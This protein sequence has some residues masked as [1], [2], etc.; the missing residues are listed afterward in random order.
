MT[1]KYK[2]VEFL[3][4]LTYPSC[5]AR[6]NRRIEEDV[7]EYRGV[8]YI[9]GNQEVEVIGSPSGHKVEKVWAELMPIRGT[10]QMHIHQYYKGICW[11]CGVYQ[12]SA[13]DVME[14]VI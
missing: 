7:F 10:A 5:K 6:L 8:A 12:Q 4:G 9:V 13:R 14:I 2:V 11:I 1:L 3:T